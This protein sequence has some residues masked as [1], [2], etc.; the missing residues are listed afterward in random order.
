M[1][2][3]NWLSDLQ[4]KRHEVLEEDIGAQVKEQGAKLGLDMSVLDE[5]DPD[6][7]AKDQAFIIAKTNAKPRKGNKKAPTR[8]A[9]TT[10]HEHHGIM[11]GP[12]LNTV[13]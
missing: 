13:G 12:D 1:R 5:I 2:T 9:N 11:A 4:K 6:G 3:Q 10:N 8:V 7:K